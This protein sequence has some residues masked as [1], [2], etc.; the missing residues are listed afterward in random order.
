MNLTKEQIGEVSR[1]RPGAG[2]VYYSGLRQA[3][4]IKVPLESNVEKEIKDREE[5]KK[6]HD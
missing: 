3:V 4:K 2:V 1:L 6:F 5:A